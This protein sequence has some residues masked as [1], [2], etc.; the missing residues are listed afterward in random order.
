MGREDRQGGED[1]GR[2]EETTGRVWG[3]GY[4]GAGSY[5]REE[6]I[7]ILFIHPLNFCGLDA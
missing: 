1:W 5:V 6:L 3:G 2:G 7:F 4:G